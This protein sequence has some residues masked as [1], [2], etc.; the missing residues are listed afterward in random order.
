MS[1]SLTYCHTCGYL[2]LMHSFCLFLKL[3]VIIPNVIKTIDAKFLNL[4]EVMEEE[5]VRGSISREH[6]VGAQEQRAYRENKSPPS[7]TKGK[8]AKASLFRLH[9]KGGLEATQSISKSQGIFHNFHQDFPTLQAADCRHRAWD[10]YAP[11]MVLLKI[12]S[13]AAR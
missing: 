13:A 8:G 11:W 2:F 3:L 4:K 6:E 1:V 12:Q 5:T 9:G 7:N 10:S